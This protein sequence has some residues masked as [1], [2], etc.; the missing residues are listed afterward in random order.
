M[1]MRRII[2][3]S[4]FMALL[5]FTVAAYSVTITLSENNVAQLG[6]TG[7]VKV[8][9]PANSC[10]IDKVKWVISGSPPY[11]VSAVEVTWIPASNATYT[12]YVTLYDNSNNVISSGSSKSQSLS[13]GQ[14]TTTRVSITSASPEAVYYVEIIIV[15]TG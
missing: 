3:L 8:N 1:D 2:L 11:E 4:I 9:C 7:N 12:V 6:G 10:Q 5:L 13:G 15:Q 14:E